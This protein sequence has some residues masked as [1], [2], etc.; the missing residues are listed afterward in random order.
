MA[1]A[2]EDDEVRQRWNRRLNEV[3]ERFNIEHDGELAEFLGMTRSGMYQF[4]RGETELSPWTRVI[5]MDKL[6]FA[7]AKE[8]ILELIPKQQAEQLR[9][10]MEKQTQK[11]IQLEQD[12]Q[13]QRSALHYTDAD[14]PQQATHTPLE[15]EHGPDNE[16]K[17][18]RRRKNPT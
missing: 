15:E 9:K 14:Q 11:L 8:A 4:R 10:S 16:P 17:K 12:R 18:K 5:I 6:G 1:T 3:K 13:R 2:Q 7:W